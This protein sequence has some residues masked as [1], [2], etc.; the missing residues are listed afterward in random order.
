MSDPLSKDS[1][2]EVPAT[3][4][5]ARGNSLPNAGA[6]GPAPEGVLIPSASLS[7]DEEVCI[8]CGKRYSEHRE[9][10]HGL[11]C[12]DKPLSS[13]QKL[14]RLIA[15][16]LYISWVATDD[17]LVATNDVVYRAVD[18]DAAIERLRAALAYTEEWRNY[19][20]SMWLHTDG[21]EER[22]GSLP[23]PTRDAPS[24]ICLCYETPCR[25]LRD[26]RPADETPAA[27]GKWCPTCGGLPIKT[28]SHNIPTGTVCVRCER[29]GGG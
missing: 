27:P 22:P 3:E 2:N 21:R 12:S 29:E 19:Y 11:H 6:W 8:V 28:C 20:R 5:E 7:K 15:P 25:C 18:V 24:G 14:T 17:N 26:R 16:K 13:K 10:K 9:D 1:S 23:R 4:A